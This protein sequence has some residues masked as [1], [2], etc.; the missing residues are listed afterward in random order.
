M[1]EKD[2][3]AAVCTI[4]TRNRFH[5]TKT[6]MET[7]AHY[8]PWSQRFVLLVDGEV[9]D[10]PF[11]IQRCE[12]VSLADLSDDNIDIRLSQYDS[13]EMCCSLKPDIILYLLARGF[14]KVIYLD[15]DML[16][17]SK[18]DHILT[19]LQDHDLILT[20]HL[21]EPQGD[22]FSP[23]D[24]DILRAGIFN[25]GFLAIGSAPDVMKWLNWWKNI[26]QYHCVA[27]LPYG[28]LH[29]QKWIEMAPCFMNRV[30]IDRHPGMNVAYWN[31]ANRNL[32]FDGTSYKCGKDDLVIFHF[33]GFMP[34]TPNVLSIY[35]T[36]FKNVGITS[37]LKKLVDDYLA[38]LSKNGM[39][40]YSQLP[41]KFS[42]FSNIPKGLQETVSLVQSIGNEL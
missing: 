17:C 22:D 1:S 20:P 21:L 24:L 35:E 19:G 3:K 42:D 8:A 15:A 2:I 29:D 31:V 41:Y 6:L 37:D 33:S 39:A 9:G 40:F 18:L 27:A 38:L 23:S 13:T 10:A 36:R 4:S 28:I 12:I 16:V 26:L 14:D 34:S 5:Q 7:V 32:K 30:L 25:A 11:V